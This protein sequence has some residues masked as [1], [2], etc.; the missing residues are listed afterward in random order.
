MT[1]EEQTESLQGLKGV[2]VTVAE[3]KDESC[4]ERPS[5]GL[6][7][8]ELKIFS[9][10][11]LRKLGVRVLTKDEH[12]TSQDQPELHIRVFLNEIRVLNFTQLST[13]QVVLSQTLKLARPNETSFQVTTWWENR[14][15]L[16]GMLPLR[17]GVYDSV[18]EILEIFSHDY[19][20][21]NPSL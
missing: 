8:S 19:F 14:T 21:A 5:Y 20:L 1:R 13:V 2:F 6:V 10:K 16:S 3:I 17:K 11:F 15:T 7:L 9:E 12:L 4:K 18:K